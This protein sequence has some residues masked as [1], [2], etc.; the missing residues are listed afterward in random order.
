MNNKPNI[1][2]IN[3]HAEGNSSDY[4]LDV[5]GHPPFLDVLA[6]RVRQVRVVE[7]TLDLMIF[8]QVLGQ[9]FAVF[10]ADAVDDAAFV[11]EAGAEHVADVG[12]DVFHCLLVANLIHQVWP[13][14]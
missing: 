6:A 5:V 4:Y 10:S 1:P 2:L 14:E 12:F 9:P 7:V 8:P 11:F 13:V 3:A